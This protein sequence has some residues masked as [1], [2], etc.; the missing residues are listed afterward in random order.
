MSMDYYI[1]LKDREGISR[2]SIEGYCAS[3]GLNA[4]MHP[5]FKLLEDAGFLPVRLIDKRF[6]EEESKAFLSGFEVYVSDY[7]HVTQPQKKTP[8]LFTKLFKGKQDTEKPFDRAVK[9]ASVLIELSCGYGDSFEVLLAYVFGAYFVKHHG[10]TFDDPQTG[11][12][13]VD[14]S[15]MED[16]I[17][18]II[19]ELK[20]CASAGELLTHEFTEWA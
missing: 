2:E 12:F 9:D 11:K 18:H 17:S 5:T 20:K 1:Y 6:S 4:S 16:E 14:S 13:F 19:A 15:Q 8:G 3:L 7:Q 10:G